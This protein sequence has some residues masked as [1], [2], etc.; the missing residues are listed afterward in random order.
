ML[1]AP[2]TLPV[3]KNDMDNDYD[4][5]GN[6]IVPCPICLNVHCISKEGGQ[7]PQEKDFVESITNNNTE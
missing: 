3:T 5:D 4:N 1:I 7:C 6:N 2:A